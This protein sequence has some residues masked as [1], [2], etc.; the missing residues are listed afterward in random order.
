MNQITLNPVGKVISERNSPDT[1]PLGG[2][3][4]II[5][6]FEEYSDALL[7]IEENSHLWVLS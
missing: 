3:D 2:T 7:R 5:E 4:S 1:M 6:I